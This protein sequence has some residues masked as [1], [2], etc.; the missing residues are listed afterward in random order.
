[1]R[2]TRFKLVGELSP[3]VRRSRRKI[4]EEE[5]KTLTLSKKQPPRVAKKGKNVA[6]ELESSTDS[7]SSAY[8]EDKEDN[9]F[10][11]EERSLEPPV[12]RARASSPPAKP[13]P[14][15][16]EKSLEPAF[17]GDTQATNP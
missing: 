1:M 6:S 14:K 5:P 15:F 11:E 9:D 16:A 4:R 13:T 10:V 12:K 2:S 3:P 7:K 17:K 8:E